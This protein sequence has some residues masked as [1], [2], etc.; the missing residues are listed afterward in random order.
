MEDDLI[1]SLTRHV[2]EEVVGRYLLERRLIEL[3]IEDL[4]TLAEQTRKEA[5]GAG[6]RLARLSSL[7]IELQM[8][9]RLVEMLGIEPLSFWGHSLDG[10]FKEKVRLIPA[11]ALTQKAKFRKV[12]LESYSRLYHWMKRYGERYK[13]VEAECSAVNRNIYCF[14]QNFDL[15]TLLSF[16]RGLDIQGIE[17]KK[18]LG[19]NF[20]AK[21]MA[22]LDKNLYIGPVTMEKLD[23][24]V[25]LDLP[26]PVSFRNELAGLAVEIFGHC[27]KEVKKILR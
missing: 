7:M 3:Q 14:Q 13:E 18:V 16:L 1:L 15:T 4:N 17:R 20:T 11:R 22:E 8:R 12:L 25:P 27:H 2:K 21:E 23:L 19:D 10:K 6:L 26:E 9:Q 5:K 24:P